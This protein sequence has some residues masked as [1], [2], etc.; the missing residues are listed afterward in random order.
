VSAAAQED[1]VRRLGAYYEIFTDSRQQTLH[2]LFLACSQHPAT[3]RAGLVDTRSLLST[4]VKQMKY[5]LYDSIRGTV[6]VMIDE[7]YWL[8]YGTKVVTTQTGSL[9]G[10]HSL[11]F[12]RPARIGCLL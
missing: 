1:D 12:W 8:R 3:Y 2:Q 11:L 7:G 10:S 9:F 4:D 6:T 5:R